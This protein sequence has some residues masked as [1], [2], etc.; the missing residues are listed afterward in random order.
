[1]ASEKSFLLVVAVLLL[2][3]PALGAKERC[4]PQDKKALLQIKKDFNNPYVLTSW[5]PEE[6]CCT[7]YCVECDRK[8]NRIVT[9]NIYL[10]VPE[11]NFSAKI[12]D[13]IGLLPYLQTLTLH[14]LPYLTGPLNPA[15]AKLTNLNFLQISRTNISG[16][17]PA[18]LA[19]L[20]KLTYI[21]L[22]FNNL[23]GSI[24]PEL[25]QLPKLEALHLDRNH[26]TGPIPASFGSLKSNP[27]IYLSHNNLSGPIPPSFFKLNLT[28]LDLSRNKLVG[29]A[30]GLFGATK[31]TETIDLSRNQF[32]FDLSKIKFSKTIISLDLNH[33]KLYGALPASLT[34]LDNLQLF[35]V[36]YNRLCGKIP[37]GGNLQKKDVDSYFHN[38]CLC[39]SPLPKCSK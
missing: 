18:F 16:P 28:R 39:G 37:V 2:L 33:N 31:A 25:G 6:D 4:N 38:K 24:P 21:D 5:K 7:W 30:S 36:S 13:S 26:L 32:A 17:V 11:T 12:P 19:Q 8:T 14:H 34:A 3:S 27:D 23:S 9:I 20:K 29:D 15:I 10:S 1:M 22:S 35:N